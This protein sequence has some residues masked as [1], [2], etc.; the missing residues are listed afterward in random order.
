MSQPTT[1]HIGIQTA[2]IA[3]GSNVTSDNSTPLSAIE[4]ALLRLSDESLTLVKKSRL[5]STPAFP[6]GSG[7]DFVNGF[8]QV[9]TT[10]IPVDLMDCLHAVER[11]MG[12]ERPHRWAPRVI[13]LDLI[14]Y[15]Q[16]VLPD[17]ATHQIWRDLPLEEQM[18]KAPDGLVLPHPRLQDRAF[19]LGPMCDVAPDW[20]HPAL[21]RT[22][23]QLLAACPAQ[24]RAALTPLPEQ[25]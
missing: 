5:F 1:D 2:F 3:L 4:T 23:A 11:D 14:A 22:A 13:D 24:D 6:S 17:P 21:G 9:E 20:M 8:V 19:V 12:R 25:P 15:G 10:L 16:Q 7:P 18:K